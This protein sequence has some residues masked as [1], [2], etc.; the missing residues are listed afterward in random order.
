MTGTSHEP[1]WLQRLRQLADD[2]AELHVLDPDGHEVVWAIARH[3]RPEPDEP[4]IWVR[5][6]T[7]PPAGQRFSHDHARRRGI[8]YADQPTVTGTGDVT[9]ATPAGQRI[10]VRPAAGQRA[11]R[12]EQWDTFTQVV[13]DADDEL[14]LEQLREDSW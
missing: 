9:M 12:L 3:V 8:T 6:I 1:A 10:T 14:E 11:A 4:V 2:G 5:P 13:L 7:G